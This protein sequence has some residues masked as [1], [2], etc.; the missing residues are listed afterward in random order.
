MDL[1]QR[2]YTFAGPDVSWRTRWSAPEV[3]SV[4]LYDWGEGV[5]NYNNMH[6]MTTSNHIALLSFALDK[7]TGRFIENK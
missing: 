5:S 4:E 3:V 7:T 1:F 6:H 2:S